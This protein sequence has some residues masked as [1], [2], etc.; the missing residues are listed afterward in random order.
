MSSDL[1]VLATAVEHVQ[2]KIATVLLGSVLFGVFTLLFFFSSTILIYRGLRV[3]SYAFLFATTSAM[4]IVS[5]VYW[6]VETVTLLQTLYLPSEYAYQSEDS[7]IHKSLTLTVCLGLNVFF[8]DAIIL[9]RTCALWK[10]NKWI[11]WISV[12]AF[13]AITGLEIAD[14]ATSK[15]DIANYTTS[16]ARLPVAFKNI[17][18][19]VSIFLSLAFNVWATSLA[20][21]RTWLYQRALRRSQTSTTGLTRKSLVL[22]IECGALYCI[23]WTAFIVFSVYRGYDPEGAPASYALDQAVVQLSGC[24]PCVIVVL[25]CLRKAR[26][27][28]DFGSLEAP[29]F[30]QSHP[31]RS[32]LPQS[33]TAAKTSVSISIPS[34]VLTSP[35]QQQFE[36]K[37]YSF[38][39]AL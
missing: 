13:V 17:Y 23:V 26:D 35:S 4:Y 1:E 25:V 3:H 36:L 29:R 7:L 24:Y 10:D 39:Q 28:H 22:L 33:P 34:P 30:G 5:T 6:I 27:K 18:G 32:L 2:R 14:A 21:A 38:G 11:R 37:T 15:S 12:V 31:S 16:V 9:W 19:G 20:A 8:G